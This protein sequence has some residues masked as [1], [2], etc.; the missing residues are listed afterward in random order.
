MIKDNWKTAAVT[1]T[2]CVI[3]MVSF[4]LVQ[5]KDYVTRNEVSDMIQTESPYLVDKQLVLQNINDMKEVL[6]DN[7]QVISQLNIEIARL[8]SELDKIGE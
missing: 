8:R 1:A 4:W 3:M 6:K 5:A 7:T 2:S